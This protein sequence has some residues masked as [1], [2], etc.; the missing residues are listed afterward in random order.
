MN[1]TSAS[2]LD[3]EA[4]HNWP[5]GLYTLTVLSNVD[6]IEEYLN[7]ST[8]WQQMS[9]PTSSTGVAT[10]VLSTRGTHRASLVLSFK[11]NWTRRLRPDEGCRHT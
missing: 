3:P 2:G 6:Y 11:S 7:M 9:L 5:I 10:K 1:K 4:V 8:N